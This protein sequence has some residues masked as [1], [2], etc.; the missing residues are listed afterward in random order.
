MAYDALDP[1]GAGRWDF[2]F[3][4][5]SSLITNL[6]IR[7]NGKKGAKLTTPDEFMINWSGEEK[8][9]K[10]Q[11]VDEMKNILLSIASAHNKKV[12]KGGIGTKPP[13]PKTKKP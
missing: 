5:L 1:I 3:A 6:A 7:V 13:P 2:Q 11:T 9:T 10:G 4:M 8:V 12:N